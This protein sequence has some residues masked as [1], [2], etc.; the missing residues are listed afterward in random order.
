M[1]RIDA[2]NA[3][4]AHEAADVAAEKSQLHTKQTPERYKRAI[5]RVERLKS[6][7]KPCGMEAALGNNS[8]NDLGI[9]R[10]VCSKPFS[11]LRH[12]KILRLLLFR[13]EH[14]LNK[15]LEA[16]IRSYVIEF[17]LDSQED[18]KVVVPLIRF[19]QPR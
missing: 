7:A 10:I 9:A 17:R 19:F 4:S 16:R 1:A 5:F 3:G 6:F 13:P 8:A 14:F 15:G 11:S 18:E 12:G 2:H